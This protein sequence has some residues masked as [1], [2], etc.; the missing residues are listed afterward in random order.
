MIRAVLAFVFLLSDAAGGT[1][2][3][4]TLQDVGLCFLFIVLRGHSAYT[5][6]HVILGLREGYWGG[7]VSRDD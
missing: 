4:L 6:I 7:W 2:H 5:P 1:V 3:S